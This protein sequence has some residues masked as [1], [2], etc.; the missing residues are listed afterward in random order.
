LAALL[1]LLLLFANAR[2]R[3]LFPSAEEAEISGKARALLK[4]AAIETRRNIMV[5]GDDSD[6]IF[7]QKQDETLGWKRQTPDLVVSSEGLTITHNSEAMRFYN[8]NYCSRCSEDYV[9]TFERYRI[10]GSTRLDQRMN[11]HRA[12]TK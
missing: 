8:G 3:S 4:M 5:V 7:R 11:R 12:L 9:I 10:Q 1:L 2:S 6:I